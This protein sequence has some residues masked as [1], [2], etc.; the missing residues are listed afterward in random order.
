MTAPAAGPA[1]APAR[2]SPRIE[3]LLPIVGFLR[4][5]DRPTLRSDLMAGLTV[6]VMLVPQAMAYAALAGMPPVT[7]LY[8][9]V[10][11]VL[12]YA[13]LGTSGSLAVG[14]VAITAL[15][16]GAALAP[17]ADG[18]PGRYVAL[19]GLLA[20]LVGAIQ[21]LLGVLRMGVL[22][23]F[24]SHSVL[25]GF[26]SAAAIVIAGSQ[27]KDLL[28][29][30]AKRAETFPEIV[31]SVA[32]ALDTVHWLTV[33]V[34]V[35]SIAGLVALRRYAPRL[36]GAL[37]VVAGV[38]AI[39]AAAAFGERGVAILR[40]VPAGLPA[41]DLP[42]L[43]LADVSALLPS[44]VAIALVAYMEGIAVAKA[45]A[46]KTRQHVDANQELV[47]VGGANVAAGFFQAFPVAGGFSR[48][49]V[50]HQAGAR[51]PVASMVTALVV[52]VTALALTPLFFH[53]P[54]AVLAA[55]VVVAVLGLV[56]RRSAVHAWRAR[57]SDG[58]AVGLT[59]LV[60]L[61]FGVEP[62][63][64]AGV[65]FSLAVFL[66]R[67]SRP[68]TAELGRVPCT[69]T[70]RNIRRYEVLTDPSVLLLRV[71]GPLYFANAQRLEDHVLGTVQ[72]RPAV[73][74]VVLDASTISDTDA[75][76]AHALVEL[77]ERLADEDVA[78]HLATV[79][80]PVR[81]LL[82]RAQAW[83]PF[84]DAGAVHPDV[85]GAVEAVGLPA[86]SPLRADC[87][88]AHVPQAVL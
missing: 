59:F 88:Q 36:P 14:P 55:I 71:D 34:A 72:A 3:T 53:L 62:G 49:A 22:V 73:R 54:K 70:Y 61:L 76:G 8:A 52:A 87:D 74:A 31:R 50:N 21:V 65:V 11:P 17:L 39:S 41:P 80:G 33:G 77:R 43:A 86:D 1:A 84:A 2:R 56:D 81:D 37:I 6:A 18:D 35:V 82:D 15:M 48:S 57:H 28:G 16:T 13:I 64:A 58:V 30:D 40:E 79:R 66:W 63:L 69:E 47:A 38:T 26:T 5:Y 45:L 85:A 83:G 67:S 32:G 51:T 24:M 20:L 60:T 68:H 25:S 9:A 23:S 10:V 29:L 75:D 12:V 42:A 19:A 78:L 27:L 46:A 7:G 44:A 4:R